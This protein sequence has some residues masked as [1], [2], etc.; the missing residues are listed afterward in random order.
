MG[1]TIKRRD[2]IQLTAAGSLIGLAA[3]KLSAFGVWPKTSALPVRGSG[4]PR[5][6]VARVYI[7]NPEG[8]WPKPGL[9]FKEEI[10][11]YESEFSKIKDE[12]SDVVFVVDELVTSPDQVSRLKARLNDIDG[13]L[14]VHLSLGI[15]PILREILSLEHP[16]MVFA[17]PYSGHEWVTFGALRKEKLGAKMECILS[18]D[19][20]QLATALRPFRA[21]RYFKEAKILDL[22][23]G[24][25]NEKFLE[26]IKNKFG[27]EVKR[28]ELERVKDAFSAV[29]ESRAK[30]EAEMWIK[31]AVKIIEP[32]KEDIVKSCRLGLAFE[33]LLDEEDAHIMTVDCYGSM[34]DKTIK[35][36]AYPCVGF[37]RLNNAGLGG[38]CESDLRSALTHILF[39]GL[40][41]RPGFISDPT[42]DESS[43]SI[44]LAHCMGTP[45]MDGPDKPA[46]LYNL[47]TVMERQEGAVPQ[48][49]MRVGQKVT[50]AIVAGADFLPYF[51]GEITE[52]PE[53]D[54]GCRTKIKVR[55]DGDVEKLWRNWSSGL[56]RVTCYGDIT[57]ELEHF[58]R[59]KE[60]RMVNE[61]E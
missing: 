40:A 19:C 16:T 12:V 33:Q 57:K 26:E 36:P 25:R 53:T 6:R 48:V 29:S 13:V 10:R 38:I 45:K 28:I 39:L 3:S 44:I 35:L 50:Q 46:A 52:N 60:I 58:C 30:T 34:W 43:N 32:S 2:F 37:A 49:K 7:G 23:D 15:S 24:Q 21:V 56:H 55:V 20:G 8:L 61:A 5:A 31:E 11:F 27:T 22:S 14:V 1:R 54:R 17:V 41:K 42:V 59:F 9:N 51:T 18:S 4:W 47:R